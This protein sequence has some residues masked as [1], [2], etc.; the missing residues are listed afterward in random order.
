MIAWPDPSSRSYAVDRPSMS[1]AAGPAGALRLKLMLKESIA[2]W[3]DHRAGSKSA[4]LAFY[5]LFSLTPILLLA[6]AFAGCR[7]LMLWN[8]LKQ[9]SF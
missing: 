7:A 9:E 6:I 4:A 3:F 5:T 1:A 2:S 8:E